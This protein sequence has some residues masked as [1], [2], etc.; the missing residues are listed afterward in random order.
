M[1]KDEMNLVR[2]CSV[3]LAETAGVIQMPN[4]S[5]PL[6]DKAASFS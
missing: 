3:K 2:G 1:L 6:R 4:E 5:A